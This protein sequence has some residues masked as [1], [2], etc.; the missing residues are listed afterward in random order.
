MTSSALTKQAPRPTLPVAFQDHG[1]FHR[2]VSRSVAA[3]AVAGGVSALVGAI[4]GPISLFAPVAIGVAIAATVDA[5]WPILI[6]AAA[7]GGLAGIAAT[8]LGTAPS[9]FAALCVGLGLGA[10]AGRK[11]IP[12]GPAKAWLLSALGCGLTTALGA[13]TITRL[14]AHGFFESVLPTPLALVGYGAAMGLFTLLGTAAAHLTTAR[15]PVERAFAKA[16]P[17]LQGELLQL[18][19]RSVTTYQSCRDALRARGAQKSQVVRLESQLAGM[20]TRSIELAVQV[21]DVDGALGGRSDL[22]LADELERLAG[23]AE[24]TTDEVARRQYL[25]ARRNLEAQADQ[26]H[27]I[28]TGRDRVVASLH[29]QVALLERTRVSLVGL[30]SSDS[31]RLATELG[32]LSE[33]LADSAR[34]MEAES[35]AV[36]EVGTLPG[37]LED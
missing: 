37:M 12:R 24:S 4:A 7:G 23:K 8:S 13:F 18:A 28:R 9:T 6:A 21:S 25:L 14:M 20:A 26:L 31:S 16:R 27:R 36:L 5:W 35:E 29:G 30:R 22:D 3:G 19:E 11:K 34:E 17:Q 32:T 10:L 1:R 33:V 15:D 2:T